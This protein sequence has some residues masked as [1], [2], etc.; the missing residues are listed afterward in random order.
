M[1]LCGVY[2]C[3]SG[4]THTKLKAIKMQTPL[5]LGFLCISSGVF[6]MMGALR[7]TLI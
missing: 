4:G 7:Y 1:I 3:G 5:I 6:Q 2:L